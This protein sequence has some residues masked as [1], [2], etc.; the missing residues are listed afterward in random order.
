MKGIAN[1]DFHSA[2][3]VVIAYLLLIAADI[4]H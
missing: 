4:V 2:C 1:D 3:S